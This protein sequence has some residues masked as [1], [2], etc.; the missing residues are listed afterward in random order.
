MMD[1][2]NRLAITNATLALLAT[3]PAIHAADEPVGAPEP[4]DYSNLYDDYTP[5]EPEKDPKTGFVVGGENSSDLIEALTEINGIPVAELEESMRPG[6]LSLAGFLGKDE[7]LLEVMAADNAW[8]LEAGLTHQELARNLNVLV[9]I[10]KMVS[11]RRDESEIFVYRGVRFTTSKREWLGYQESPFRDGTKTSR[12]IVL[13]NVDNGKILKFSP[14]VPMMVE[15]YG[16]YEGHGTSYRVDPRDIVKVL[17]FL[18]VK[19]GAEQDG[20]GQPATASDS[21]SEGESKSKP[22]SEVRSQ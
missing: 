21:K 18:E 7:G 6:G 11:K 10:A 17:T 5:L 22:E 4:V 3:I 12:D 1:I 14:L 20:V 19:N 13:K 15:R 9:S 8:V 2:L 16:F